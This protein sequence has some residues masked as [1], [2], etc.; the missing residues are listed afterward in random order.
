MDARKSG[1]GIELAGN[2]NLVTALANA[3][4]EKEVDA[5]AKKINSGGS[6]KRINLLDELRGLCVLALMVYNISYMLGTYFQRDWFYGA[7]ETMGVAK[8]AFAALFIL[9]SGVSIRLSR[10]AGR[11]AAILGC[12][13]LGISV[14]TLA[15]FP[16]LGITQAGVMF[17]VLHMLACSTLLYVLL[18]KI[19][20]KCPAILGAL[21]SLALFCW[22]FPLEDR[23]F[24]FF[25]VLTVQLPDKL[26]ESNALFF[27]GFHNGD[28]ARWD[29][30]PLLPY[31]FMF[32]FGAFIGKYFIKEQL[33]DFCYKPHF[34]ITGFMGRKA[35]IIFMLHIPVFYGIAYLIHLLA[36]P[37]NA[38]VVLIP[39]TIFLM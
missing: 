4:T 37:P 28:F 24:S 18:R 7:F 14:V 27:L 29:Y 13:A 3:T 34:P 33:P 6:Q 38:P 26:Y 8:P 17:G 35:L 12:C 25:G 32:L 31:L 5:A 19:I 9:I 22:T 20:E 10:D 36:N 2:D 16:K 1:G 39:L 30:F 23:R 11:R 15:L 21:I